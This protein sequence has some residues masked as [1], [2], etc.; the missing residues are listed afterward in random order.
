MITRRPATDADFHLCR[1]IHHAAYKQAVISQYGSWDDKAQDQFF[2]DDWLK[3]T[4]EIICFD[5][6]PV[7]YYGYK[8]ENN[9]FHIVEIVIHPSHQCKGIG[10]GILKSEV[11]NALNSNMT[12]KLRTFHANR[13]R[14]LYERIGFRVYG[15]T[16]THVLMKI[17]K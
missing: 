2:G 1:L 4:F 14:K 16:S 13:A 17:T 11:V 7:G 10:S 15:E 5:D 12:V 3:S 8:S 9:N 6:V